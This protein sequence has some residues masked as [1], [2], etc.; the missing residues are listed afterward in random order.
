MQSEYSKEPGIGLSEEFNH[1][2][3]EGRDEEKA[4]FLR[5]LHERGETPEEVA[6]LS[7]LL[8]EQ[9]KLSPVTDTSDIVGTGGDGMNTINVSTAAS[10]LL[11][12]FGIRIAKHG[13][14]GATSNKGSADFLKYLGYSFEMDQEMLEGRLRDSSFAFILAPMYNGSFAQF[15]KARKMLPFKTVFNFMG[16]LTNPA[17]PSVMMMGVTGRSISDLY[18]RYLLLNSKSGCV[19][20]SDDGMDEISPIATSNITFVRNGETQETKFDPSSFLSRKIQLNEISCVEAEPSFKLTMAGLEGKDEP[21]AEFISLNAAMAL[22][23]NGKYPSVEE[24][25]HESL[26]LLKSGYVSEHV[27][28]IVGSR[29]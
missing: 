28:F 20:Y 1:L 29:R 12:S 27:N 8:R 22:Y 23:V 18:T 3:Q 24:G 5:E 4:Q 25:F 16:P 26:K 10:L 14:F 21:A 2:L 13:N 6:T 11:S 19:V 15:A 9:A 7:S 17:D